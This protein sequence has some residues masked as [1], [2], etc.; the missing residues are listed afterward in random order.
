MWVRDYKIFTK[1]RGNFRLTCLSGT[2]VKNIQMV[3]KWICNFVWS[4]F[5]YFFGSNMIYQKRDF[6]YFGLKNEK[7]M[8]I[9]TTE[10]NILEL[11][12]QKNVIRLIVDEAFGTAAAHSFSSTCCIIAII[13]PLWTLSGQCLYHLYR[14]HSWV[15]DRWQYHQECCLLFSAED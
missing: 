12:P 6:L 2:R 15:C 8:C 3:G 13:L 5:L 10:R 9:V 14:W 7:K 1:E 4:I 11:R